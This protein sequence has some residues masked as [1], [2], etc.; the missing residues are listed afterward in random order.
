MAPRFL[1]GVKESGVTISRQQARRW[2]ESRFGR[3]RE[4]R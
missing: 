4:E 2:R 1:A 3:T